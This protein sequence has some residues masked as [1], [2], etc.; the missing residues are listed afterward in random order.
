MRPDGRDGFLPHAVNANTPHPYGVTRTADGEDPG[1]WTIHGR[2]TVYARGSV[3]VEVNDVTAPAGDRFTQPVVHLPRTAVALVVADGSEGPRVLTLWTY[4]HPVGAWGHE[5][6]GGGVDG[7]EDPAEAARREAGEETGLR[8]EGP[9]R[10]LV[11]F[12]PRPGEVV[13][14]VHVHLWE[15]GGAG[16]GADAAL[17]PTGEPRD[18]LEP[19]RARWI[20]LADVP[21]LA[22]SGLLLGSGTLV[23][24]L[25]YVAERA[26][27]PGAQ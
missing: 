17:E 19:G 16:S 13:G 25:Q 18:P 26:A 9:G 3:R 27:V 14:A 21:A 8:P 23:G 5:L 6:P 4:R 20:D 22:A 15:I 12:E 2:S 11:A 7:D 10:P 24:L 1:G